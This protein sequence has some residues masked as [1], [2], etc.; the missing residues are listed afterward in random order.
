MG[1]IIILFGQKITQI[2]RPTGQ[3]YPP[4]PIFYTITTLLYLLMRMRLFD[5]LK[6]HLSGY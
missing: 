2:A 1:M 4:W 5:I 3:K 6:Y